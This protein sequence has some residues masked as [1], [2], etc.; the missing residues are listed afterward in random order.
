MLNKILYDRISSVSSE[1]PRRYDRFFFAS[2]LTICLQIHLGFSQTSFT[3]FLSLYLSSNS[4]AQGQVLCGKIM[5]TLKFLLLYLMLVL[6][7]GII[8]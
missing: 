8:S 6:S 3:I 5:N 2:F 1:L 7:R 4:E